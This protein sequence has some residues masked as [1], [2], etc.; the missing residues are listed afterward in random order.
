MD[1]SF[2]LPNWNG[3]LLIHFIPFMRRIM[4]R[5]RTITVIC[6]WCLRDDLC[7]SSYRACKEMIS[8]LATPPEDEVLSSLINYESKSLKFFSISSSDPLKIGKYLHF[9]LCIST[10]TEK[11]FCLKALDDGY[12]SKNYVR[13]FVRALHPNWRAKVM[14][15]EDLKD[16]TSLS[17]D[18][19]IRNL[20]V[21]EMIIK[22]DY[23]IVKAKGERKSLASKAKKESSDEEC[24]TFEKLLHMDL[25]GLS[26]IRSYR[27]NRYALGI[28]D[29]YSRMYNIVNKNRPRSRIDNEVQFGEC[30]NGNG[31]THNFS[32]P[33]TPQSNGVVERK[34]M[35]L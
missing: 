20:K 3:T 10:E 18:E 32:A 23:E 34:N 12:S 11:G 31:S 17:L 16:L 5:M 27:G 4:T 33:R 29:D 8:H 28:V 7:I 25:L 30:Y 1:D 26:A 21:Y 24:L 6:A 19:L 22:K 14:V 15:I 35:T 9:S 2:K 13:K